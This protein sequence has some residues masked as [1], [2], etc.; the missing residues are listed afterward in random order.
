MELNLS[1]TNTW[2]DR[3][4][5]LFSQLQSY[6]LFRPHALTTGLR[7]VGALDL[8][9]VREYSDGLRPDEA[10][11]LQRPVRDP[12]W[13]R[14]I[15]MSL[16]GE[17]CV[18]ARSFTPL[19]ASHGSWQGMRR[20]RTRPLADMLYHDSQ[21][22]RSPFAVQRLRPWQTLYDS[23]RRRLEADCP[24]AREILT[25]CSVFRRHEQPLLVAECFLPAFWILAKKASQT[26]NKPI[27]SF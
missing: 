2:L 9:V 13:I 27:S 6:W 19:L 4:A 14:E 23:V 10:W 3:P 1:A 12:I 22:T 21:V 20:L 15:I 26:T 16:D 5:P 18:F 17:P 8:K 25:R 7:R 11:T 24:P